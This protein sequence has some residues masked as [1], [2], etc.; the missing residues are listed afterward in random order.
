MERQLLGKEDEDKDLIFGSDTRNRQQ[1]M[2]KFILILSLCLISF[3]VH[4]QS[5]PKTDKQVASIRAAYNKATQMATHSTAKKDKENCMTLTMSRNM[6]GSGLS[7]LTTEFFFIPG[8]DEEHPFNELYL[9]RTSWNYGTEK[10]YREFLFDP[11]SGDLLFSYYKGNE[12][13]SNASSESLP[14]SVE[15]RI[16]YAGTK[17]IRYTTIT[18]PLDPQT[19]KPLPNGAKQKQEGAKP[20][21]KLLW[22]DAEISRSFYDTFN[23]V[24]NV[25]F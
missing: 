21:P 4:A 18:T 24:S 13:E 6:P 14:A 1:Q 8:T 17:A 22:D 16:Y 5:D 23:N 20:L 11:K 15:R 7:R 10:F 19:R 25:E 12:T 2:K 3:V 9:V